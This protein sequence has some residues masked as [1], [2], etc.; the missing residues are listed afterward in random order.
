MGPNSEVDMMPTR[1]VPTLAY[2]APQQPKSTLGGGDVDMSEDGEEGEGGD[3]N[4]EG[5]MN[6]DVRMNTLR[7]DLGHMPT[8]SDA[9][10]SM[11][12]A[13]EP[14]TYSTMNGARATPASKAAAAAKTAAVMRKGPD[15]EENDEV[16]PTE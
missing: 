5:T 3:M 6:G 12:D 2:A 4:A 7:S 11:P 10:V 8:S 13:G 14:D 16:P 15:E 9:S 1:T